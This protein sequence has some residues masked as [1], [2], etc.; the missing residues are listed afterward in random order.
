M[1]WLPTGSCSLHGLLGKNEQRFRQTAAF[2]LSMQPR[3]GSTYSQAR[4]SPGTLKECNCQEG[5]MPQTKFVLRQVFRM[6]SSLRCAGYD[7]ITV[8][9]TAGAGTTADA[10][11]T[12]KYQ[13][14]VSLTEKQAFS[15]TSKCAQRQALKLGKRI[16]VCINKAAAFRTLEDH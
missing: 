11:S 2:Y 1:V 5:P 16:I 13:I 10:Q 7:G 8:L 9:Q 6:F 4:H 14:A 12:W 15:T 3:T